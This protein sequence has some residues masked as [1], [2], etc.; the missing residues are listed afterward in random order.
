MKQLDRPLFI[1]ISMIKDEYKPN[2]IL[3]DTLKKQDK[4]I[5][6]NKEQSFFVGDAFILLLL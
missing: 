3:F 1:I 6:I 2:I 4:T 5:K